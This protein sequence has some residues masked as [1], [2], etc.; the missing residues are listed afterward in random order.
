MT[1]PPDDDP[2]YGETFDHDE[3]ITYDGPD[4]IQWKCRRFGAEGF[5]KRN[6]TP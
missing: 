6:Q 4:G 5:E 2:V 3:T 1:N